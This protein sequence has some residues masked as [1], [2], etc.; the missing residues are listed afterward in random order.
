MTLTFL[1]FYC[2]LFK[3]QEEHAGI[4]VTAVTWI[5]NKEVSVAYRMD[6]L[7]VGVL[8]GSLED[9]ANLVSVF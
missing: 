1:F 3:S 2:Y 7:Y 4:K 5:V 9:V 8:M 6:N